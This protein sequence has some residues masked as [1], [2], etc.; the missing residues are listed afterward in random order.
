MK[1]IVKIFLAA[2]IL[3]ICWNCET[4]EIQISNS[5]SEITLKNNAEYN[6]DFNISG[7]EEGVT[8]IKQ[9]KHYSVSELIRN[10]NTNWSVVYHYKP[11]SG[12]VGKDSVTFETCTGGDGTT[13][14]KTEIVKFVFQITD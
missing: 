4:D 11:E 14:G 10:Q 5:P 12:Y 8:I 9:A 1:T 6:H 7:D 3:L 2:I 13:C